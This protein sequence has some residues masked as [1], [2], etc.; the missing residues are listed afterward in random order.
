[1]LAQTEMSVVFVLVKKIRLG[2]LK[3]TADDKPKGYY[4]LSL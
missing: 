2:S 1:M 4:G 3:L